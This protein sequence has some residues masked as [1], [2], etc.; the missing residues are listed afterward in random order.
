VHGE[1]WWANGQMARLIV[2]EYVKYVAALVRMRLDTVAAT[3]GASRL[4][5]LGRT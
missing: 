3:A 1:P 2:S 4:S 5:E